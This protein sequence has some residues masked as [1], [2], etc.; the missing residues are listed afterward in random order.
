MPYTSWSAT[1]PSYAKK[2]AEPAFRFARAQYR[3]V[4][5]PVNGRMGYRHPVSRVWRQ[6]AAVVVA[7]VAVI[8]GCSSDDVNDPGGSPE[9]VTSDA[10]YDG[11]GGAGQAGSGGG[12]AGSGGIGQA[13]SGGVGQAGSGGAAG[14]IADAGP[15]GDGCVWA[16]DA[17][18]CGAQTPAPVCTSGSGDACAL[19]VCTCEGLTYWGWC[20]TSAVP[21]ATF[22]ECEAGTG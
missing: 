7:S 12:Q 9:H 19:P 15:D 10:G 4:R 16:Y 6:S 3:L 11:S 13:G 21:F 1:W 5:D 18:G 20:G 8:H 17:P 2:R 14:S 22:G